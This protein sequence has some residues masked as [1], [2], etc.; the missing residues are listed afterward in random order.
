ME[1][2]MTWRGPSTA[3]EGTAAGR[4]PLCRIH[5]VRP[6][7]TEGPANG[8]Q[9]AA[10][11]VAATHPIHAFPMMAGGHS[12]A[13]RMTKGGGHEHSASSTSLPHRSV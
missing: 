3:D 13:P 8:I 11:R 9:S 1:S 6:T 7:R 12:T 4:A 2:M 5:D 10:A